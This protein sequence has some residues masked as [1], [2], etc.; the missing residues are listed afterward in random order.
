M[1]LLTLFRHWHFLFSVPSFEAEELSIFVR[2]DRR[3]FSLEPATDLTTVQQL[4]Y[5][6]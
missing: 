4:T 5:T 6:M 3:Y 1:K 2:N